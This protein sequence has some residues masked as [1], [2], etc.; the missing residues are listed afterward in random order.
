MTS[1]WVNP[2]T[3]ELQK[4]CAQL[5]TR[6]KGL[7][8]AD[9]STGTIGK[10]FAAIKVENNENNRRE[11]RELLLTTR[12][13][14]QYISGVILYEETLYQKTAAGKPFADVI[15]ENGALIGIK[16]DKGT[17]A[18]PGS[19]NESDTQGLDDL[20]KRCAEYYKA[21]ARFAKW[22]AVLKV[23]E[24]CPT[25]AAIKANAWSL[26]RY[27]TICLQNGLVPIVEPEVLTD[28]KHSIERMAAATEKVQAACIKALHDCNVPLNLIVLKPN[29]VSSGAESGKK[30]TPEEVAHF[31]IRTLKRTIPPAVSSILFLSGGQTEEE[32]TL[33]LNAMNQHPLPWTLTFSYGRALQ[34]TVLKVWSG[35]AENVAAAKAAYIERAKANGEAGLGKYAGGAGGDLAKQSNYV[36]GY[37]Y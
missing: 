10:R 24:R 15:R 23:D 29:M 33:N 6:G 13:A 1:D 20:S 28:G 5:A 9:E 27:A 18:L 2:F 4:T 31:T 34:A 35:K 26:A 16:V 36:A 17:V 22:R 11:Y 25:E 37:K 14:Y 7:L 19:D 32:A 12:E 30:D 3:D 21:G 8:A